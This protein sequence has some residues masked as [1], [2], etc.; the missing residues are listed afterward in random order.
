MTLH[1]QDA[2]AAE[3]ANAQSAKFLQGT[4]SGIGLFE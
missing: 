3:S 2:G 1:I 4:I